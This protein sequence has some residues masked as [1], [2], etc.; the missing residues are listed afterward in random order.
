LEFPENLDLKQLVGRTIARC[1]NDAD[2]TQEKLAEIAGLERGY[3]S[4][5]ERG[6]RM[7]TVETVFRLCRGLKLNPSELIRVI[8]LQVR[9][10]PRE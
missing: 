10:S 7:P 4:L 1:R 3:I 9:N 6:L 2:L 8:E 5:M